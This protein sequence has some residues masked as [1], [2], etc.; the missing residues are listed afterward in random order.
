M[1]IMMMLECDTN[2][3]GEEL[4]RA[5]SDCGVSELVERTERMEG[6]FPGTNMFFS[7]E[8]VTSDDSELRAEN[9][10]CSWDVGYRCVFVYVISSALECGVQLDC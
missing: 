1:S 5:F 4:R 10:E 8:R 6:N 7:C 9:V 3:S 2:T